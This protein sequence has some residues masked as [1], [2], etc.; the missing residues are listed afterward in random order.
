MRYTGQ[1]VE[2]SV[3]FF[4]INVSNQQTV[5]PVTLQPSNGGTTRQQGVELDG[6]VGDPALARRCSRT[7]P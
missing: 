1:K 2:G 3:G 7:P 5:D 4:L 6:G